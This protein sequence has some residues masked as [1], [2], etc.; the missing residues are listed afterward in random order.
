MLAA[1]AHFQKNET[2]DGVALLESEIARN[3]N[4]ETLLLFSAQKFFMLGLYTNALHVINRKLAR[5]PDD[6]Q[7]IYGKGFA[8]LQLG[9]YNDAVAALSRILEIQTNNPD[10]LFNRAFAY[11]KSDRL[12]AARADMRQLQSTYANSFQVAYGLGEI[13]S[14][15][16]DTNEAIRNFKIYLANAP[17][18]SGEFKSVRERLTQF[19]GQ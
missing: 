4:D 9:A 17:T 10:A 12:D 14:R 2:A 1:A 3:P 7:W 19:G 13:A 8:S 5:T 18:N 11:F 15:Q 16:H 6:P